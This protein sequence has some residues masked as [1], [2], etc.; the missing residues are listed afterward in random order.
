MKKN[1]L[2]LGLIAAA[3]FTLTNC[4]QELDNPVEPSVEGV[5]FEIIASPVETKTT[6]D[7]LNTVW[8]AGDAINVFHAK[9]ET[10]DYKNDGKFTLTSENTFK[11]TLNDEL[12][13]GLSCN[14][15]AFYPYTSQIST[16]ANKTAYVT[17]AS[18]ASSVQ[19]QNENNSMAHIAGANYPLAGVVTESEYT[20]GEPVE[21]PMSHLTSLLEVVVT[22]GTEEPLTVTEIILNAP[23]LV[24]GTFY[25]NFAGE[26]TPASF[27]S[28][29]EGYT[30]TTAK[31]VVNNGEAL[32][33]D[34]S[35]KFYLAVK[36]FDV[37]DQF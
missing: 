25:I 20:P 7:G 30:S 6:N 11:G 27:V 14:W 13:D 37:E 31:L 9:F 29:G 10:E 26:I 24:V 4:T 35:A 36:P 15:Y 21:I 3:A 17:V 16:P 33:K 28:S 1:F 5:P 18:K 12:A 34:A 8:A 19:T 2:S 23:E 22:N 32:A